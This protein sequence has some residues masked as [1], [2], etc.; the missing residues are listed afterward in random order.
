MASIQ[1]LKITWPGGIRKNTVVH[2]HRLTHSKYVYVWL[3]SYITIISSMVQHYLGILPIMLPNRE[4]NNIICDWINHNHK[5]CQFCLVRM[6]K[7]P[8][9]LLSDLLKKIDKKIKKAS[10]HCCVMFI[11][12]VE[13]RICCSRVIG[14]IG[15]NLMLPPTQQCVGLKFN[16]SNDMCVFFWRFS[17]LKTWHPTLPW[18]RL[19]VTIWALPTQPQFPPIHPFN[20]VENIRHPKKKHN[21]STSTTDLM[22]NPKN[23]AGIYRSHSTTSTTI[24][25]RERYL[26]WPC[27]VHHLKWM[28]FITVWVWA[29]VNKHFMD[30]CICMVFHQQCLIQWLFWN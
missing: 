19:K 2:G 1:S 18:V 24:R 29:W 23:Q 12:Y 22:T 25:E 20:F 4:I 13:T 14:G 15:V 9:V 7:T 6:W 28:C 3:L 30:L 5:L 27:W 11:W 16:S 8:F 21:L 10:C 26:W 17:F